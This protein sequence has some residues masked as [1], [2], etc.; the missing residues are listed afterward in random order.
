MIALKITILGMFIFQF[1]QRILEASVPFEGAM[2][3]AFDDYLVVL[4][5]LYYKKKYCKFTFL[6]SSLFL[7]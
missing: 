5:L 1:R 3:T 4:R 6:I 2:G 7:F